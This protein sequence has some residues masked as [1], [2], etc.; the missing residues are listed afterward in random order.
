MNCIY[1]SLIPIAVITL[2]M[3][4]NAT[5]INTTSLMFRPEIS[6]MQTTLTHGFAQLAFSARLH[7]AVKGRT[8]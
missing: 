1:I 3:P 8:A 5:P 7:R 2:A 4:A 6:R